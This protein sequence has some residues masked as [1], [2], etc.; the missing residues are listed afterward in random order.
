MVNAQRSFRGGH[1]VL[2]LDFVLGD[3]GRARQT[4]LG[5]PGEAG[6]D[7]RPSLPLLEVTAAGHGRGWSGS[8]ATGATTRPATATGTR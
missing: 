4:R 5:R 6:S 2:Q 8:R 3:D 1:E 7:P